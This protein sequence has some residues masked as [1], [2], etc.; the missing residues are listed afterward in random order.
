VSEATNWDPAFSSSRCSVEF[1]VLH[2]TVFL[3]DPKTL[4]TE[5]TRQ[6]ALVI[7]TTVGRRNLT[8]GNRA[9]QDARDSSSLRLFGMTADLAF[10]WE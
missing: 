7:P 10:R 6:S 2:A 4:P 9:A 3:V 8:L 5:E 1:R